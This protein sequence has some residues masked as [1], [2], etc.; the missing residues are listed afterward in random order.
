MQNDP[1]NPWDIHQKIVQKSS[2]TCFESSKNWLK[3]RQKSPKKIHKNLPTI[4]QKM[5]QNFAKNHSK[6]DG[7]IF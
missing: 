1:K 2:K 3:I 7:N 4:I 5:F 6:I